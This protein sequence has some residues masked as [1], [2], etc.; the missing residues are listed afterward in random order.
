ME[1]INIAAIAGHSI[2]GGT[3]EWL[4]KIG[5]A[6]HA[7]LAGAGLVTPRQ[8]KLPPIQAR[9][10]EFLEGYIVGRTDV[11]KQTRINLDAARRRLVEYFGVEN[12]L[13]EI[14]AGDADA[15]VIW[16]KAQYANGTVGR[17]VNRAKQFFRAAL[18]KEI[19]S[20][21]PFADAKAPS[22]VNEARK[23]FVTLDAAHK[24][25]NACP[26]A[27]WRLL[28]AL[29]RFGGL[30]CPSEHLAM[31]WSD[32]DWERERFRVRSPKTARHEGKE[33]R[34]VPIFPE[35]R[36]YLEEAF[37]LAPEGSVYVISRY[38]DVEKNFRTRLNRIIRRA[39]LKP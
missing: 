16:L 37:E 31:T 18:R 10:G 12:P 17:T 14:T 29:S 23:F 1:S 22:Q 36:P 2:D 35:L 32:V 39:G 21:N 6:L 9:L 27:E 25:L 38:R 19:I 24:V 13:A 15:W 3:A 20:K 4:G 34:W 5:D 30:R 8:G 7:K 26:D 28:F 11:R 33:G